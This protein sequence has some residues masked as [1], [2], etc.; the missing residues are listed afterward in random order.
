[1]GGAVRSQSG[2]RQVYFKFNIGRLLTVTT[3]RNH[4][5]LTNLQQH[6]STLLAENVTLRAEADSAK[7]Q[8]EEVARLK[9]EL[10]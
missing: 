7:R 6:E 9:I 1:M 4:Q 2:S 5:E 10:G 3:E 8:D